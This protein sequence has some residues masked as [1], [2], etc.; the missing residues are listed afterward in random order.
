MKE[1]LRVNNG[2][3][4]MD[5]M[6]VSHVRRPRHRARRTSWMSV[7]LR[8]SRAMGVEVHRSCSASIPGVAVRLVAPGQ[9]ELHL[10][11]TPQ[12]LQQHGFVHTTGAC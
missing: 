4:W 5:R 10:P 3:E 12:L 1:D 8:S 11:V 9:C 2:M 6:A 7:A